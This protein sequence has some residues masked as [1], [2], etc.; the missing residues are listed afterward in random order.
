[1]VAVAWHVSNF[2]TA[3]VGFKGG[4]SISLEP[5]SQCGG[6][7]QHTGVIPKDVDV[8]FSKGEQGRDVDDKQGG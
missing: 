1:M 5:G 3:R 2:R 8:A 4:G 7:K 6:G